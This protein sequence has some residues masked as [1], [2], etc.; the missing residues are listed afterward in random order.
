MVYRRIENL[1]QKILSRAGSNRLPINPEKIA[2][3]LG[4]E[5][6][7]GDLGKGA[8]GLL[9]IRKG[10]GTIGIQHDD[11][12]VRQRFSAAHELG[13]YLLHRGSSSLFIDKEYKVMYRDQASATG[14]VKQEREANA[15]AAALLMPQTFLKRDFEDLDFSDEQAIQK[16]AKRYQVSELAMTYRITNL[17]LMSS[18][19]R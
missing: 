13:H 6:K 4:L 1:A 5:I 8:S 2:V 17:N 16:L 12:L 10:I 7:K 14:T 18:E 11:P 15:F 3:M 9:A 19:S